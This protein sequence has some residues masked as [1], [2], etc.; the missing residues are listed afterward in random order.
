MK[1][2][3]HNQNGKPGWEPS[4]QLSG[5]NDNNTTVFGS[6]GRLRQTQ[7]EEGTTTLWEL[8]FKVWQL[9]PSSDEYMRLNV[10]LLSQ[11]ISH[12]WTTGYSVSM[13]TL[14]TF[15]TLS[16]HIGS[17]HMC[18]V[19]SGC[20]RRDLWVWSRTSSDELCVWQCAWTHTCIQVCVC[21]CVCLC[22]VGL[23][24]I[25]LWQSN[26][27]GLDWSCPS[28]VGEQRKSRDSLDESITL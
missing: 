11:I 23:Q 17:K 25:P 3:R 18:M 22:S 5:R 24:S 4:I 10:S 12:G 13:C 27:P 21:M 1:Q 9:Q 14:M 28:L 19:D 8:F 26:G 15:Y 16:N 2:C 7:G 6:R 20:V